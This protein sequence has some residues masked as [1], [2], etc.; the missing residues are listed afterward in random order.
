VENPKR[1]TKTI[2]GFAFTLIPGRRYCAERPM[3]DG[4]AAFTVTVR[5]VESGDVEAEIVGLAYDDANDLLGQFNNG[6]SSWEGRLWE[7]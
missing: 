1:T 4:R 5:D 6:P 2:A 3:D 7:P